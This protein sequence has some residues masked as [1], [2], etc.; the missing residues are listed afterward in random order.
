MLKH[1][2]TLLD[3]P[4]RHL[5]R[6]GWEPR[7][8]CSTAARS[9][10]RSLRPYIRR[11]RDQQTLEKGP[12]ISLIFAGPARAIRTSPTGHG[13]RPCSALTSREAREHNLM[14]RRK[15]TASR[16]C[17]N[18]TKRRREFPRTDPEARSCR[19]YVAM[20]ADRARPQRLRQGRAMHFAGPTNC[21]FTFELAEK[22]N[23]SGRCRR[24][25]NGSATV[26]RQTEE[27]NQN[28]NQSTS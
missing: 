12:R 6:A 20:E 23:P 13:G 1:N 24:G 17:S 25:E 22:G 3:A 5:E 2:L 8:C 19:G 16:A 7:R 18:G 28:G 11:P 14:S 4:G 27:D 15:R 26:M 10:G 9:E 21:R